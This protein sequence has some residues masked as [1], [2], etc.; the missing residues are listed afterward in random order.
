MALIESRI[1]DGVAVVELNDPDRRNALTPDLVQSYVGL[2]DDL[3]SDE[4]VFALVVTGRGRA[5]C[6]GADLSAL[7]AAREEGLRGIYEMFTRTER[8]VL[9]TVAA[10]NGAAVG[11]GMN[12]ALAC[13]V[14]FAGPFAKFDSRFL[15]LGIHPGGGHTWLADRTVGPAATASMVLFGRVLDA[16]A[17][18]SAG[19]VQQV[20]QGDQ[21]VHDAVAFARGAA[22]APRD[23]LI[24]AKAT[25]R[26]TRTITTYADAL[27]RELTSQL[28]SMDQPYFAERLKALR[29]KISS[30]DRS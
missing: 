23:L 5:F 1:E 18:Q 8:F 4:S 12:L 6:A 26:D 14:R 2:L 10:V 7:G 25:I 19:L 24:E 16:A 11:A 9:P 27:E 28:W 21:L 20:A 29:S 30:S 3:E 13:D 17:A 22:N 15:S